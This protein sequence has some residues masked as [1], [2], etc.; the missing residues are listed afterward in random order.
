MLTFIGNCRTLQQ[1]PAID[2]LGTSTL[3]RCGSLQ[4]KG[5]L[6][7]FP[8]FTSRV[9]KKVAVFVQLIQYGPSRSIDSDARSPSPMN[10]CCITCS[11]GHSRGSSTRNFLLCPMTHSCRRVGFCLGHSV[12]ELNLQGLHLCAIGECVHPIF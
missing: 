1:N 3:R 8:G 6:S 12:V 2:C 10:L 5:R 11:T 7:G 4:V 9:S